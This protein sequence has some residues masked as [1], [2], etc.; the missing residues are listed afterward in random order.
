MLGTRSARSWA[1]LRSLI[2]EY[3]IDGVVYC[4]MKFCSN[5]QG[6][7]PLFREEL[8]GGIAVKALE[9]DISGHADRREVEVFLKRLRRRKGMR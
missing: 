4:A 6:Q 9:S 1:E 5:L 2:S 3:E 8:A 7:W